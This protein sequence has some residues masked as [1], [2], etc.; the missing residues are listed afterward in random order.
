MDLKLQNTSNTR[1][2]FLKNKTENHGF[3]KVGRSPRVSSFDR[4]SHS[5]FAVKP[6]CIVIRFVDCQSR[7][8]F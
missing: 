2:I 1:K 4:N 3:V 7:N 8:C 6:E 5:I